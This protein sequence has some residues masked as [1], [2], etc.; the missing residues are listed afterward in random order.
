MHVPSRRPRWGTKPSI[1]SSGCFFHFIPVLA[2]GNMMCLEWFPRHIKT[3]ILYSRYRWRCNIYVTELVCNTSP[4]PGIEDVFVAPAPATGAVAYEKVKRGQEWSIDLDLF[5]S[6]SPSQK[7]KSLLL[8]N[9]LPLG[10]LR[11]QF[12]EHLHVKFIKHVT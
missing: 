6:A 3:N 8:A 5:P 12:W 4:L 9:L 1:S 10:L 2:A 7:S 11:Y